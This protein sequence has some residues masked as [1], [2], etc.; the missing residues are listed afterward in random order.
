M[1]DPDTGEVTPASI[2]QAGELTATN[3]TTASATGAGAGSVTAAT[4]PEGGFVEG[5]LA[6]RITGD[7]IGLSENSVA[8]ATTAFDTAKGTARYK[9]LEEF[10]AERKAERDADTAYIDAKAAYDAAPEGEEKDNLLKALIAVPSNKLYI[11][12][13]RAKL[14]VLEGAGKVRLESVEG[15]QVASGYEA[16]QITTENLA[17][18]IEI[19]ADRGVSIEDLPAYSTLKTRSA[20]TL[21]AEDIEGLKGV[22]ATGTAGSMGETVPGI[23]T[24]TA[25]EAGVTTRSEDFSLI[26]ENKI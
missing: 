21:D 18:L 20:Q 3:L 26:D 12:A 7:N 8:I 24:S 22:A 1:T 9:F 16:A 2:T 10:A 6:S 25:L 23:D 11:D 14:T 17:E 5:T 4:R 15:P 19:A 13:E